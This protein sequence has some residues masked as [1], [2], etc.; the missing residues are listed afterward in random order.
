MQVHP[1][2]SYLTSLLIVAATVGS[3]VLVACTPA[4]KKPVVATALAAD[5]TRHESFE[6]TL[7]ELDEH[8]EYV[9]EMFQLS[10]K[11]PAMLDRLLE[12]TAMQL[13]DEAFARRSAEHI[14]AHPDGLKGTLAA[15]LV[16]IRNKPNALDAA[17][18]AI[19][20]HPEEGA[21]MITRRERAV[22]NTIHALVELIQHDA[23]A[24]QAFVVALDENRDL[25]AAVLA[26]HPEVMGRLF[27]AIA[28]R[29]V[30]RG[31]DKLAAFV[32]SLEK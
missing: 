11:H 32:D 8:P 30:D 19:E 14:A 1:H 22:R 21:Y 20:E 15:T 24:Q 31:Q 27:K 18:Q 29:G 16:V 25:T 3:T 9:D 6:A 10:L 12:N 26:R 4:Q 23:G 5:E 2:R 28:K 17:A 13:S 7:R